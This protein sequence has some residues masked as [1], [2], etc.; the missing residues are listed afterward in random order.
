V[1][2]SVEFFFDYVSPYSYLA[3]FQLTSFNNIEII[4]RPILLGAVMQATNNKPPGIIPSKGIYIAKDLE[5][6]SRHYGIPFSLNSIFPQNTL[7]ALR[8]AIACQ[9]EDN[10]Q[11]IHQAFFKAMF[12]DNLDLNN[13]D[14][15]RDILNQQQLNSD[16]L[17]IK[18]SESSIKDELKRNT[19]EAVARGAFGAPTFFI[20]GEMFFGNDRLDF[21]RTKLL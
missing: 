9:R 14:I 17:I 5:L 1:S 8:L 6:W 2:K 10:F 19:N 18:A 21:I 12:V 7:T 11:L 20:D 16:E 15:L 13:T 3:D 4:Y